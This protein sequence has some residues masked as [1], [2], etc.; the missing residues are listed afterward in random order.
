M[1]SQMCLV[2]SWPSYKPRGPGCPVLQLLGRALPQFPQSPWEAHLPFASTASQTL[3]SLLQPPSNRHPPP[4]ASLPPSQATAISPPTRLRFLGVALTTLSLLK[5]LQGAGLS[6]EGREFKP[7]RLWLWAPSIAVHPPSR[8][9]LLLP[10][11][12]SHTPA[13]GDKGRHQPLRPLVWTCIQS[14]SYIWVM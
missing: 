12:I 14:S 2:H 9:C 5:D 8:A 6:G 7:L 3:R 4:S 13:R 10:L 1:D 11:W